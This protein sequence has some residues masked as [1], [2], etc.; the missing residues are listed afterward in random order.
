[1]DATGT[2]RAGSLVE[3]VLASE[4]RSKRVKARIHE[5]DSERRQAHRLVPLAELQEHFGFSER[6]WR[7]RLKDGMP[8]HK[9][10]SRLRF[11]PTE[12]EAWL[13]QRYGDATQ[14]G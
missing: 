9:W 6:W 4:D 3:A 11:S 2:E 13:D 14:T 1:M 5:A 8:R 10:G 12:V 7:Y